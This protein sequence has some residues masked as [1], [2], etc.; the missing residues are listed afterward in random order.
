MNQPMYPMY[1][2]DDIYTPET[3]LV[4]LYVEYFQLKGMPEMWRYIS[5]DIQSGIENGRYLI[6]TFGRVYDEKKRYIKPL[7]ITNSGYL[8]VNLNHPEYRKTRAHSVHRLSM[9][10][11]CPIQNSDNMQVN[12]IDE[13]KTH[14]WIWN[15]E[16]VT[17]SDNR[18]Y[19]IKS[20]LIKI[21]GEDNPVASITNEQADMIGYLLANTNLSYN[22]IAKETNSTFSIVANIS[23]GTSWINVYNKYDLCRFSR[24]PSV[25][26]NDRI[27]KICEYF[28]NNRGKILFGHRKNFFIEAAL[29]ANLDPNDSS[30]IR[31][32]E[33]LYYKLTHKDICSLYNY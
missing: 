3:D 23:N 25:T 16:W 6:S 31:L 26:S 2:D 32:I 17:C 28:Q 11:F 24:N 19:S 29:Y 14:N 27:H 18:A 7:F 1:E 33:R 30:I 21:N 5:S 8:R 4:N 20:G 12:H 15:L 10:T 9:K 22:D 13:V